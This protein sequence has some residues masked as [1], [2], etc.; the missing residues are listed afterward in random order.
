MRHRALAHGGC[1][2]TRLM[3]TSCGFRRLLEL[4]FVYVETTLL[5]GCGVFALVFPAAFAGHFVSVF[6]HANRT[7]GHPAVRMLAPRARTSC[8]AGGAPRTRR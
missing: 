4:Y 3:S 7:T 2:V 5:V 1:H 6:E 8:P